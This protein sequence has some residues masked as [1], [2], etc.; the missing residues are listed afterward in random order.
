M[1]YLPK[2]VDDEQLATAKGFNAD[3]ETD[4]S[5]SE[6]DE[7]R[8]EQYMPPLRCLYVSEEFDSFA[9]V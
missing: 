4:S 3:T 6:S 2:A 7:E 8:L 1:V 5:E 9:R